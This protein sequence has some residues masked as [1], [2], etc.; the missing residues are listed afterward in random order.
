MCFF[1]LW[2]H[3]CYELCLSLHKLLCLLVVFTFIT[4]FIESTYENTLIVHMRMHFQLYWALYASYLYCF[5][6]IT[7][8]A[9]I[10]VSWSQFWIFFA[11]CIF[12]RGANLKFK[13]GT[14]SKYQLHDQD[15]RLW[16]RFHT[17]G[18]FSSLHL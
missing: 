2:Y 14:N 10:V 18:L 6:N 8:I 12:F 9:F 3:Y 13:W 11:F 17:Q 1:F 4:P 15:F 16:F 7:M 5:I